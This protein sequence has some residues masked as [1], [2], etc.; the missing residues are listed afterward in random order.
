MVRF[1]V[2]LICLATN[3]GLFLFAI[4]RIFPTTVNYI[5]IFSHDCKRYVMVF[6]SFIR[7]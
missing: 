7:A 2:N 1:I 6:F 5:A 4:T 3:S